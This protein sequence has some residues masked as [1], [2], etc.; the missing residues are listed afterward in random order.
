[1]VL[2]TVAVSGWI[3][4]SSNSFS[5][6]AMLHA[7]FGLAMISASGCAWN[8]YVERY[9]DW[10]MPRTAKRPLPDQ[11]LSSTDVAAFGSITFGIGVAYLW[12]LVNW[13]TT[14]IAVVSWVIYVWIY[15]PLKTRTWFNTHIGAVAG[16]M[17]VL[18]GSAA[19]DGTISVAGWLLFAVL[20]I[21]QFPHF[22]AIAWLYREDYRQG[23]L[24]MVSVNDPGGA[25]TG[26]VAIV[27][28]IL[29]LPLLPVLTIV[30]STQ[31]LLW[32][33]LSIGTGAWYAWASWCFYRSTNDT[34]ARRLFRVSIL[35]LPTYLIILAIARAL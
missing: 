13:Q 14:A 7:M 1:M 31:Y 12:A 8:Q 33:I 18:V 22:M 26:R 19:L 27:G 17:P 29:L 2:L 6:I 30:I 34:T 25:R 20:L 21:W 10:L 24:R 23:G 3:S 28:A 15:T 9:V 35:F 11:R 4:S 16:A 32:S 5:T